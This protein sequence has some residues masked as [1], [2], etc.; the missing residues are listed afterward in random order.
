M[1]SDWEP[2]WPFPFDQTRGDVTAAEINAERE[3]CQWYNA[4]YAT[5]KRQI[6]GLNNAIIRN[7]GNFDGPT[8]RSSATTATSTA[9]VFPSRP[10]S[11]SGTLISPCSS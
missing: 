11:S 4:Q 3:M 9:R 7:N 2:M 5:I 10:P 8:T 1:P 6:A